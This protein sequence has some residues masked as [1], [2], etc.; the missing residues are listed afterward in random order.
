MYS[1]LAVLVF[2]NSVLA[3]EGRSYY[4]ICNYFYL[5]RAKKSNMNVDGQEK[6]EIDNIYSA[7]NL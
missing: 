7:G 5:W 2:I 3:T 4:V 1:F 6:M